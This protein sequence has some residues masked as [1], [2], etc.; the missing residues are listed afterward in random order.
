MRHA[1]HARLPPPRPSREYAPPQTPRHPAGTF[2]VRGGPTAAPP[3]SPPAPA[4]PGSPVRTAGRTAREAH[5]RGGGRAEARSP[6]LARQRTR[7]Y[8][9]ATPI[10]FPIESWGQAADATTHRRRRCG[11]SRSASA[12]S[13]RCVSQCRRRVAHRRP[14]RLA[15]VPLPGWL[16]QLNDLNDRVDVCEALPSPSI[17]EEPSDSVGA[18]RSDAHISVW[19]TGKRHRDHTRDA[20]GRIRSLLPKD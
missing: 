2:G 11:R 5:R 20:P 14:P 15:V 16:H 17:G 19:R 6:L 12:G 4:G 1:P 7:A 13:S 10:K 8:T 9:P 3:R 18:A